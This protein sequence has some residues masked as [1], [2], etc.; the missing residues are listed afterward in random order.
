[1]S[2]KTKIILG[3]VFGALVIL[4]CVA[5]FIFSGKK[6]TAGEKSFTFTIES[7]RDSYSET[8]DVHGEYAYLGEYLRSLG[9]IDYEDSTYG[10]YIHG[11]NGMMD[12]NDNQYWWGLFVGEESAT[13]GAD[14]IPVEDGGAYSLVL[15]QGW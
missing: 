3:S 15:M 13:T 2:K 8:Y 10:M 7:E 11:V 1:M 9:T 14:E 12:D 4:A 6:V 5:V